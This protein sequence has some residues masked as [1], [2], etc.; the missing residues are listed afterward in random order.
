MDIEVFGAVQ[1]FY[2]FTLGAELFALEIEKIREIKLGYENQIIPVTPIHSPVKG[3][4]ELGQEIVP[5]I[6][7]SLRLGIKEIQSQSQTRMIIFVEAVLNERKRI[8]GIWIDRL[9]NITNVRT[10]DIIDTFLY[11]PDIKQYFIS[12][13][14]SDCKKTIKIL[15]I[16]SILTEIEL[17]RISLK[18]S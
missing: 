5:I 13:R 17:L 14:L 7:L 12:D 3:V 8:C 16:E 4:M 1:T 15:N 18:R 10:R 11:E 9:L 6:D 2:V